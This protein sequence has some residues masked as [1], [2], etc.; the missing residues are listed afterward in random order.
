[1]WHD[2]QWGSTHQLINHI[3]LLSLK[4]KYSPGLEEG[5]LMPPTVVKWY[6]RVQL[7]FLQLN[8][9]VSKKKYTVLIQMVVPA[10][11]A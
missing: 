10:V 1:M 9:P 7:F 6:S 3:N 5:L 4:K 2:R 11:N 8:V